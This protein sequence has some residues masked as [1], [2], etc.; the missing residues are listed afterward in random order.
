MR[1]LSHSTLTCHMTT[2][3]WIRWASENPQAH[4]TQNLWTLC[5]PVISGPRIPCPFLIACSSALFR[6]CPAVRHSLCVRLLF[7]FSYVFGKSFGIR[8]RFS[9]IFHYCYD[10]I[11]V[12]AA[13]DVVFCWC[14]VLFKIT[15]RWMSESSTKHIHIF[16]SRLLTSLN[17]SL[18]SH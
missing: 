1:K 4:Q 16:I 11:L 2:G 6:V 13:S 10:H 5:L 3:A 14:W 17:C 15:S 18:L 9:W 7:H 8:V 12:V